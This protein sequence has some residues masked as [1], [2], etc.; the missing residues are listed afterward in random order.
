VGFDRDPIVEVSSGLIILWQFQHRM[1]ET[2]E[3]QALRLMAF[4]SWAL[5]AYV[6]FE[7]MHALVTGT[8]PSPHLSASHL[9]SR[10]C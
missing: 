5:A 1:P 10:P 3:R 4:S 6:T 7:S 8:A 9:P 2:R